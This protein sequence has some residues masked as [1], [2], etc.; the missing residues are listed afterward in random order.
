MLQK[1]TADNHARLLLLGRST[2]HW[3]RYVATRRHK[4]AQ[5]ELAAGHYEAGVLAGALH[6]FRQC[7]RDAAVGRRRVFA[8]AMHRRSWLIWRAFKAWRCASGVDGRGALGFHATMQHHSRAWHT[9][10]LARL[11]HLQKH[12]VPR[13]A[14]SI[15]HAHEASV[16]VDIQCWMPNCFC[17]YRPC[18]CCR[19]SAA[20]SHLERIVA[21]GSGTSQAPTAADKGSS[22][23]S[24][25]AQQ[26]QQ[27]G[28]QQHQRPGVLHSCQDPASVA[29]AVVEASCLRQK[30]WQEGWHSRWQQALAPQ[31]QQ[32]Q[33][34]LIH[35][36]VLQ[37]AQQQQQ[38]RLQQLAVQRAPTTAQHLQKQG[39]LA[40]DLDAAADVAHEGNSA[41]QSREAVTPQPTAAAV[42][43]EQLHP[44]SSHDSSVVLAKRLARPQPRLPSFMLR[45]QQQGR[46]QQPLLNSSSWLNTQQGTQEPHP[47][48][49]SGCLASGL[50]GVVMSQPTT[51]AV[52]QQQRTSPALAPEA[53]GWPGLQQSSVVLAAAS[54][55]PGV[56][57]A[58]ASHTVQQPSLAGLPAAPL[59]LTWLSPQVGRRARLQPRHL[60]PSLLDSCGVADGSSSGRLLHWQTDTAPEAGC[61]QQQP[62]EVLV[63]HTEAVPLAYP[64]DW[65]GG[66]D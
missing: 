22:S 31:Q 46:R 54:V 42:G 4:A 64:E 57:G 1:Q 27:L 52:Q 26:R 28:P 38:W 21:R 43:Q 44:G 12:A 66:G 11:E 9:S 14:A 51:P 37:P 19:L 32:Q 5:A 50:S 58:P 60:K 63:V 65:A 24:F 16:V 18:S 3:Q 61:D 7:V 40:N 36:P 33:D 25:N 10:Q 15:P 45:E 59:L 30:Q 55:Q 49:L 56:A 34:S 8:A 29:A 53:A 6:A 47:Q 41:A 62:A 13:V 17:P 23:S 39:V 20:A 2:R 48:R 35:P